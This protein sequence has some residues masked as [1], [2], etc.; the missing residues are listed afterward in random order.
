MRQYWWRV[1][2]GLLLIA[3]GVLLLLTQLGRVAAGEPLWGMLA[4]FAGSAFFLSLWLSNRAEWWPVIPGGIMLAWGVSTLLA[5]LRFPGWIV[6]PIGLLG[7]A[8]PF[9]YIYSR[10]R[11][12][13]WWALIPGGVMA[14]VGLATWFGELVGGDWVAAFVLWG[15]ALAFVVVFGADRRNWWALIP[16]GVMAVIG[17]GVSPVASSIEVLFALALIVLGVVSVLRILLR[18]S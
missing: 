15:I 2:A 11:K 5:T 10:D 18:R 13:N 3:A 9:V 6:G 17:L 8:V 16:A 4:L 12:S 7:S 1:I 14:V